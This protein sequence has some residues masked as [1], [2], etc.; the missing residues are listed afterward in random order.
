MSYSKA[1]IFTEKPVVLGKR[2]FTDPTRSPDGFKAESVFHVRTFTKK[3]EEWSLDQSDSRDLNQEALSIELQKYANDLQSL[4]P[5]F[6]QSAAS[7]SSA[8]LNRR[9][10]TELKQTLQKAGVHGLHRYISVVPVA[11]DD[12][13]NNDVYNKQF[14]LAVASSVI[15]PCDNGDLILVKDSSAKTE[16]PFIVY[17]NDLTQLTKLFGLLDKLTALMNT[18]AGDDVASK[19]SS[20][21]SKGRRAV[22]V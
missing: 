15:K 13:A 1:L 4:V 3:G 5:V 18:K 22:K 10:L 2:K 16:S 20:L 17:D 21:L 7:R 6:V 12:V 19:K 8:G 9:R 11:K 14:D